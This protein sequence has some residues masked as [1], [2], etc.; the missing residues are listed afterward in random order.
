MRPVILAVRF[1]DVWTL[2]RLAQLDEKCLYMNCWYENT[3]YSPQLTVRVT[4]LTFT[5]Y[6]TP[7]NVVILVILHLYYMI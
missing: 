1:Y 7:K 5:I 2:V 4:A 6:N 3:P